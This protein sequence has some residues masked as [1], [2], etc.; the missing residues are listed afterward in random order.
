MQIQVLVVKEL[1][2]VWKDP[3]SRFVLIGPPIIQLLV[4]GY[5]AT[6]DLQDIP[7]AFYIE[8]SG[9]ETRDLI[10]RFEGSPIFRTTARLER[11]SDIARV[12]DSREASLVVHVGPDFS[13]DLHVARPATLQLVVDGRNSNTAMILTGY[14]AAIVREFNIDWL[15]DHGQRL[16]PA[17]LVVRSWFNPNL[18]SRWFIVPG[19]VALLT[20]VVTLV[21]TALSVAR[22]RELGTFDQLLVTPLRPIQILIGKSLAPLLI[23]IVEGSVIVFFAVFWFGV[24]YLGSLVLLYSSLI[25]FLLAIIGVGL[26]I[27]SLVRTQQQAILGAF[28]FLVPAIILSGFATPIRNMSEIVQWITYVNPMRY[29]LVIVRGLFLQGMPAELVARQLWPLALIAMAS[30]GMAR[31]LFKNRTT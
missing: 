26:M 9:G 29:F 7:I 23:G 13:R 20:L 21:V 11:E 1:L 31:W 22:E 3:R 12:I 10:A 27:S 4:F 14:A 19:I 5:A 2:A 25:F 16:P 30:I 6:Y 15:H 28:L 17:S 18:Q 8:D 24:P